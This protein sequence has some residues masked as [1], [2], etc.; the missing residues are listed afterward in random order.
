MPGHATD[1]WL[2]KGLS[3]CYLCR[4]TAKGAGFEPEAAGDCAAVHVVWDCPANEDKGLAK[5]TE[6]CENL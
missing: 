3:A 4:C 6:T 1:D 2:S 5:K